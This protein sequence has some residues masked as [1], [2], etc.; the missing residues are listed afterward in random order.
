MTTYQKQIARRIAGAHSNCPIEVK[1]GNFQPY[2]AGQS[3]HYETKGGRVIHHPSAYRRFGWSN[4]AYVASTIH[5][6][7]GLQWIED[8]VG[9]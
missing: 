8:R 7:V 5:V 4:M 2:V 3:Y 1:D 6:V 9:V